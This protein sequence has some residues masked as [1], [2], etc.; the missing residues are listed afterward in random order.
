M[1]RQ[2]QKQAEQ[3]ALD[4]TTIADIHTALGIDYW[5]VWEH[6]TS[7]R[8]YSWQGA[9]SIV[10]RRLNSLG[11]A[12]DSKKRRAL[13]KEAGEYVDYLYCEGKRLANTLKRVR[14][15]VN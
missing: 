14:R 8:A 9:K 13:A 6:V 5:E 2:Q 3:M 1:N 7:V 4:G 12:G 10:T 11:R 15:A